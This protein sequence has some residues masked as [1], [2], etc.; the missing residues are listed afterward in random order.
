MALFSQKIDFS[1]IFV[2]LYGTS[3]TFCMFLGQFE[4]GRR[5]LGLFEKWLGRTVSPVVAHSPGQRPGWT[6]VHWF[7]V[8]RSARAACFMRGNAPWHCRLRARGA[9]HFCNHKNADCINRGIRCPQGDALGYGLPLGLQPAPIMWWHAIFATGFSL[10]FLEYLGTAN[11][12][13]PMTAATIT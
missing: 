8:S 11:G 2:Y 1:A 7:K 12:H 6:V 5:I 3:L 9:W 10:Y 4:T 13:L